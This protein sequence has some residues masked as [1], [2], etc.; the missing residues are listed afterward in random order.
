MA[1]KSGVGTHKLK[2][3]IEAIW[4]DHPAK[5]VGLVTAV[6]LG[7]GNEKRE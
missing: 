1:L 3:G 7:E 5:L 6:D 2:E 4:D